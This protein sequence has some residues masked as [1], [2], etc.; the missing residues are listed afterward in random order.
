MAV[1][2]AYTPIL[3]ADGYAPCSSAQKSRFPSARVKTRS[4]VLLGS[5]AV[6]SS[7]LEFASGFATVLCRKSSPWP[8]DVLGSSAGA[9]TRSCR[10]RGARRVFLIQ[11]T[12]RSFLQKLLA[13]VALILTSASDNIIFLYK[14]LHHAARIESSAGK[15][16][17]DLFYSRTS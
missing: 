10:L 8:G 1:L 17:H 13:L 16:R 9:S 14:I 11:T 12:W 15:K 7:D 3:S 4:Q 5:R 6:V 2:Q